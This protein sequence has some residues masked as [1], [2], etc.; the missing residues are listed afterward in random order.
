MWV[1]VGWLANPA[2][3]SAAKIQSPLRSPVNTR[4]VRFPPCAAGASPTT[5]I[6][7]S[8]GPRPGTGL[9]Q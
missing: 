6:R 2:R 8:A 3:Q 9:P 5:A 1:D 7:A 4:P